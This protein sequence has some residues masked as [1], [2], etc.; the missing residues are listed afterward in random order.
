[1]IP[2]TNKHFKRFAIVIL[3]SIIPLFGYSQLAKHQALYLFN[4]TRYIEW[5]AEYKD[6]N[7]IIGVVGSGT[8]IATEL[9]DIASKRKVGAQTLE[10]AEFSTPADIKK[11]HI[12][13]VPKGKMGKFD[14][15]TS[16]ALNFNTLIVTEATTFPP[17]SAINLVFD[18]AKLKYDVNSVNAKVAGLKLSDKL[19][20]VSQ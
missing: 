1:M 12:L 11:C 9:R 13:F 18:G 7:F 15:I 16:K 19:I 2:K 3:L 20:A 10:I 6:G 14:L 8:E 5:P 4:F 17:N